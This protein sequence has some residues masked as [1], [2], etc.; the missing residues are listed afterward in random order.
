MSDACEWSAREAP[1]LYVADRMDADE[2]ERFEEHL[3]GCEACQAEVRAGLRVR[4]AFIAPA[5]EPG[6]SAATEA[7][8]VQD[9]TARATPPSRWLW[10][11]L[12]AAAALAALLLVSRTGPGARDLGVIESPGWFRTAIP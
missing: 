11:P 12:A 9:S 4:G 1:V 6:S 7:R 5:A 3:V 10:V 2:E 8:P